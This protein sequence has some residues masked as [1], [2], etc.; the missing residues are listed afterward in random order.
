[1][2]LV[3]EK[4]QCCGC[5]TCEYVCPKSAITMETD[6]Q[7]F[8]YPTIDSEKCIDCGLCLKKCAFQSGYKKRMEFEP[9]YGYAA[10]HKDMDILMKSR[11]GGA[12]TAITDHILSEGGVIYGA[13]YDEKKGFFKVVHK[14]AETEEQRNE[15]RGSKYVQSDLGD[16]FLQV[17]KDLKNG[18][19]VLFS[20][21]G[22]QV[23]ALHTFLGREY[24]NLLTLDIVCHGVPSPKIWE[25][26]LKMREK[27]K[28][29]KITGVD[30]RDKVRFG[31][32]GHRESIWV[33]EKRYSS[34]LY[35][36]IFHLA[37]DYRP[38]CFQCVYTN[39][40]R[41]GD[42]T[43]ADFWGHEKAVP[44]FNEDNK[45]VSL[46]LVNTQ[47]GYD[48]WNIASKDMDVIDCTGYPYRHMNMKRPT[49]KPDN[50][51]EFWQ[52]YEEN[53]F[54]FIMKKYCNY[55]VSSPEKKKAAVPEKKEKTFWEKVKTVLR[56]IKKRICRRK[57][58]V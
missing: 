4:G 12:F 48:M 1:M 46:V 32:E 54:A 37:T 56:K 55:D 3:K 41:V 57:P 58:S 18:R 8:W 27:E 42:I 29:G 35:T 34:K 16:V 9:A 49:K 47:K 45:G 51:D 5:R 39:R 28:G 26:F 13:G 2:E 15:F 38:S 19:K 31:W 6:S 23:G 17:K 10:R 20:G 43:I 21:T 40:N 50:Y 14:R 44:G 36:K 11:S 30:F 24:E 52:D 33:D 22:C 53:G 25:D 7:G